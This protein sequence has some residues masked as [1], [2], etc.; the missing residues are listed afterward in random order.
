MKDKVYSID[1][2]IENV[3]AVDSDNDYD[4][5]K[6]LDTITIWVHSLNKKTA[7]YIDG[8][9]AHILSKKMAVPLKYQNLMKFLR[10]N[11]NLSFVK[12]Y[13]TVNTDEDS[14]IR[15]LID[16]LLYNGFIV[17]GRYSN[18]LGPAEK[19][20]SKFLDVE[21][22]T[23]IVYDHLS[24][25]IEHVIILSNSANLLYPI[26]KI[27]QNGTCITIISAD[28]SNK[29]FTCNDLKKSCDFY[30]DLKTYMNICN[31]IQ[32]KIKG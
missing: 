2:I 5:K 8:S 27:R 11:C 16:F 14:N 20:N 3:V 32:T 6:L 21:M 28:E 4:V 19:Q 12:F 15:S 7:F 17:V 22:I 26:N 1:S 24:N 9:V 31:Y 23:D 29:Q 30:F 25:D 13:L 10:L 18:N